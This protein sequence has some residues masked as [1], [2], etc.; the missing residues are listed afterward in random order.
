MWNHL[1]DVFAV[2]FVFDGL[3]WKNKMLKKEVIIN[4]FLAIKCSTRYTYRILNIQSYISYI[5]LQMEWWPQFFRTNFEL[6]IFHLGIQ[7]TNYVPNH[8]LVKYWKNSILN[9]SKYQSPSNFQIF[10]VL[11][12]WLEIP[13]QLKIFWAKNWYWL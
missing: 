2:F 12:N 4:S 1:E 5:F 8:V 13:L 11:G 6:H 10:T 9:K 3:K 7:F